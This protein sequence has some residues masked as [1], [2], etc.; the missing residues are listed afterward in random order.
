MSRFQISINVAD[1]DAA[2]AFYEKLFGVT[3]VKHRP[4]YANFVVD[5]PPLKLIVIEKEGAPGTINHLGI[6]V[7]DT[8]TVSAESERLR[9]LNLPTKDD[10]MHTCCFATQ[11]KVWTIDPDAVPWELYT[12]VDDAEHFGARAH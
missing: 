4:G 7:A 1:A 9:A 2:V 10:P 11:E 5:D 6:E 12:V 3:P 8:D